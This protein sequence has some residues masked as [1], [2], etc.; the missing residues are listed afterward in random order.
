LDKTQKNQ[1]VEDIYQKL[2]KSQGVYAF[3]Y[4]G[5]N[6][7]NVEALRKALKENQGEMKVVKNTLA[8]IAFKKADIPFDE[9]ILLDQNA[10]AF[11]YQDIVLTA[12]TLTD[13][14]K[15]IPQLEIKGVWINQQQYGPEQVKNLASLPTRDVLI[16]QVVGGIAAP[17]SGLV[18]VL[19]GTVRNLVWVLQSI[20]EKRQ[21][22][23]K[24]GIDK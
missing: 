24:G 4:R 20:E 21:A 8:H 23:N 1:I 22:I 2:Q 3:N 14:A 5:I 16:G 11:S 13:F 17:L 15:K 18:G 10:L 12:K 6:V 7:V 19:S 9:K